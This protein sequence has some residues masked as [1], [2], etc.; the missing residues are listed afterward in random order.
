MNNKPEEYLL[1]AEQLADR[2]GEVMRRYFNAEDI[3]AVA[4]D[5]DTPVTV[6][7]TMINQMVIDTVREVYPDHGVLGEEG[8]FAEDREY[9]WVCD[10]IDG[11]FPFSHGIPV[12]TFSLALVCNGEPV[13]AV[14]YDPIGDRLASAI[15]GHGAWL[16]DEELTLQ[17]EYPNLGMRGVEVEVWAENDAALFDDPELSFKVDKALSKAGFMNLFFCSIAYHGILCATG[18]SIGFVFAGRNAWD[19]A[20]VGLIVSEAG[21]VVSD[22]FGNKEDLKYNGFVD[23]MIIA[24]NE[25]EHRQLT[26]AVVPLFKAANLRA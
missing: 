18:K 7:D 22:C 23:G 15:K 11:T 24:R 26:D 12:F 14:L 8:S 17:P 16:N 9:L 6:A 21:G 3:G 19:V 2:A 1:F 5:N 4:K 20:A 10:P 13:V 25:S